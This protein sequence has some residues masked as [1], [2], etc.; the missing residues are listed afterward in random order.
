M[1]GICGIAGVPTEDA[2]IRRMAD[3]IR[4]RGPD[5]IGIYTNKEDRIALGHTRLSI[6]DLS[7]DGHQPMWN[8][9]GD[10]A[11]VFN[12]EIYNY[13]E[14][15]NELTD[16]SF[17]STSDT[18][19]LLAA[20]DRWGPACVKKLV[21]MFAF[22]IWSQKDKSIFCARDRFGVKPFYYHHQD[23]MFIFASEIKAIVTTIGTARPDLDTWA[24]Y[25]AHG[26]YDHGCESFFENILSLEPGSTMQISAE[27]DV[28][29][30]RYWNL[31]DQ[32]N[33]KLDRSR[34]EA[35]DDIRETI[36][37]AVRI[38][39]RS[40]VPIGI[41]LS[42]GLD[43]SLI[44]SMF[45]N[46]ADNQQQIHTFTSCFDDPR[47]DET[48]YAAQNSSRANLE[49][50]VCRLSPDEVPELSQ[51][52]MWHEEAPFGGIATIGYF[53]LH[54]DINQQ[55]I[56][57]VIEGQG[58]DEMFAGYN[59]FFGH[60]YL[61]LLEGGSWKTVLHEARASEFGQM[62]LTLAKQ[63]KN[64]PMASIY[65]DGTQHTANS[66]I[67]PDI[68]NLAGAMPSFPEP[69]KTRLDN[70]QYRELL[71]TKLPRVLRMNDKLSMAHSIELRQPLLD[72]RV[73]EVAFGLPADLRISNGYSKVGL[74]EVASNYL[75]HDVAWAHKR[76]VV[77]PQR[78]W[79]TGVLR[80][81]V[82]DTI[83][84]TQFS[85]LGWFDVSRVKETFN[86]YCNSPPANSFPIWQWMNAALWASC[87]MN[88]RKI[89]E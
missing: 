24:S 37:D 65:Q 4:H 54:G 43:S 45:A 53:K 50:H 41:N 67:S 9:R 77:T 28:R 78:E 8:T 35:I 80:D 79:M 84:S 33:K 62:G 82:G 51:R 36:E 56:K 55:G 69:F 88:Q 32:K 16:Y 11:I 7:T 70:A 58:G 29:I 19:V 44:T 21:G 6:I 2:T 30:R 34:A 15:R 68:L 17:K 46:M 57:V 12:G 74:R 64:S 61:D 86:A 3:S 83:S 31:F 87:F 49:Q 22:T 14:L 39:M 13:K 27:G 76:A 89:T 60:Y 52:L 85:A 63:M 48:S 42:G 40:D 47:Y 18:E 26:I 23:G 5:D 25:L 66:C 75:L 38:R 10:M 20:Y 59:V 71:H 1:C 72:H 81:W 73:A